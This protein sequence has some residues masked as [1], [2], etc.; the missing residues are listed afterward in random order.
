MKRQS[1]LV[2]LLCV[3]A[4]V[5]AFGWSGVAQ[6][7]KPAAAPARITFEYMYTNNWNE[8][9]QRGAEGW[10]LVSVNVVSEVVNGTTV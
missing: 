2:G 5:C 3:V 8:L 10:E 1:G 7:Q 6:S 9:A 4:A